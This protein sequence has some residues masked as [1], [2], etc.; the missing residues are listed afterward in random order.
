MGPTPAAPVDAAMDAAG[1]EEPRRHIVDSLCQFFA[2]RVYSISSA[3]ALVVSVVKRNRPFLGKGCVTHREAQ[4]ALEEFEKAHQMA[5][6]FEVQLPLEE[7]EQGR[8]MTWTL[9]MEFGRAAPDLANGHGLSTRAAP[10]QGQAVPDIADD[11]GLGARLASRGQAPRLKAQ[12]QGDHRLADDLGVKAVPPQGRR[13]VPDLSDDHGLGARGASRGTGGPPPSDAAYPRQAGCGK[14]GKGKD[15]QTRLMCYLIAGRT[16][17]KVQTLRSLADTGSTVSGVTITHEDITAAI[18]LHEQKK[19]NAATQAES[20]REEVLK[21]WDILAAWESW[22]TPEWKG[23]GG[24][25]GGQL[26]WRRQDWLSPRRAGGAPWPPGEG[27]LAEEGRWGPMASDDAAVLEPSAEFEEQ[28]LAS[29]VGFLRSKA[30]DITAAK[31][32]LRRMGRAR[33]TTI[34]YKG[35]DV[36]VPAHILERAIAMCEPLSVRG[37]PSSSHARL[38]L[39]QTD[40]LAA[41]RER[42]RE[43]ESCPVRRVRFNFG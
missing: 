10:P 29:C 7:F 34:P 42:P 20:R 17:E 37:C 12:D 39:E 36:I 43:E 2:H 27:A 19:V 28:L 8:S 4:L 31:E 30:S 15:T 6:D 35:A 16:Q 21:F 1:S 14:G 9:A 33:M 23:N 26:H 24:G 25:S 5:I 13:G 3:Q 32:G 11:C 18:E 40:G 41:A 22:Q 38:S